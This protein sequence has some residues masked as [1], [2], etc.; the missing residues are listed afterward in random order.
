MVLTRQTGVKEK[1]TK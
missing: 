1:N